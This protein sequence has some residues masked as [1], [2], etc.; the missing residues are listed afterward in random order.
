MKAQ[1]FDFWRRC[2]VFAYAGAFHNRN[3]AC[4]LKC[5]LYPADGRITNS[6]PAEAAP[7]CFEK[8]VANIIVSYAPISRG[9]HK[10]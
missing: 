1:L 7:R 9:E 4:G 10:L 8:S 2:C 3:S 5:P 6:D